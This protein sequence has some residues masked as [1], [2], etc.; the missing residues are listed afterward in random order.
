LRKIRGKYLER[1]GDEER[2]VK[3]DVLKS[4]KIDKKEEENTKEL[5]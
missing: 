4:M 3:T 1:I 2:K 5:L